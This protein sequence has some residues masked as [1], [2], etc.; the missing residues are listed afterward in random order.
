MQRKMVA[1][2]AAVLVLAAGGCGSSGPK[3]LSAAQFRQD[4]AKIC[5]QRRAQVTSAMASS[6]NN[7]RI[8]MRAANPAIQD[9]LKKLEGVRPP[10][11]L[12]SDYNSVM[13]FERLQ[14][15]SVT[16]YL[17]TGRIL[18]HATEDGPPL[19]RHERM[20]VRLGM[21]ACNN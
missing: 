13:A 4:V 3:Q 16:A 1:A 8:A 17:K 15:R 21:S 20:R 11:A 14:A 9:A 19:H 18:P 5:T 6:R 2:A 12:L 10:A 7:L